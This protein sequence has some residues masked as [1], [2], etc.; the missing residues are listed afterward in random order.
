MNIE[1]RKQVERELHDD[2]RGHHAHDEHFTANYRFYAVAQA[3]IDLVKS[4][5]K[6]RGPG[7]RVLDYCCGDGVSSQLI[8]Q[9]GAHAYGIDISPVSIDNAKRAA[10][11]AGLGDRT[12]FRVMD[13]E[14]LEFDDNFFDYVVVNGVL[15]HLDLRRAY[16]ELARVV[17]PDGAVIATE[18]LRHNALIRWYRRRTPQMRSAWEVE[19]I[20]G[21]TEIEAG[22]EFFGRVEVLGWFHLATLA[23]V[24][25]R[26]RSGFH[27]LLR[28]LEA[29]DRLVLRVPGL[30][31]QAWMAV[32]ELAEPRER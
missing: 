14:A 30:R 11:A 9:S 17:K 25:F 29:A 5:L 8:A 26:R 20:L 1:D 13:A 16:G 27:A 3:N 21:R 15:H 18:A 2:L 19:H 12:T 22:R 7:S 28:A 32:F 10:E 6:A 24:P 23:A 31:W 4:W